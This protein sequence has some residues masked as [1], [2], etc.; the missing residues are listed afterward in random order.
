VTPIRLRTVFISMLLAVAYIL[1]LSGP[2]FAGVRC[3]DG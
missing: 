2:V 1:V 3:G